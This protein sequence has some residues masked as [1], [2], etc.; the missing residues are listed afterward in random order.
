MSD[1]TSEQLNELDKL[2]CER[3]ALNQLIDYIKDPE[4]VVMWTFGDGY[5]HI[6]SNKVQK[7]D[8]ELKVY[9]KVSEYST[10]YIDLFNVNM[11][12]VKIYK[13]IK[14]WS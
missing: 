7:E 10:D 2:A 9:F 14:N 12:D 3:H 6:L 5:C 4:Y 11:E 8:D 13:E 1:I